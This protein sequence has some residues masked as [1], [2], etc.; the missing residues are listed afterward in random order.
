MKIFCSDWNEENMKEYCQE[1]ENAH[2]SKLR[3]HKVIEVVE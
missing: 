2:I 3:N 1:N